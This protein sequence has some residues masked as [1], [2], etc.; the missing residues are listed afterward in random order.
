MAGVTRPVTLDVT[1]FHCEAHKTLKVQVCGARWWPDQ[2]QRVRH[3]VRLPALS[4][5]M[6]LRINVEA[7]E[8]KS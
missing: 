4:D 8:E 2:A 3:R 7:R 6:T 5:E 1:H